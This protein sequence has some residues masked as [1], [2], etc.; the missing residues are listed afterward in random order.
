LQTLIASGGSVGARIAQFLSE[1]GEGVTLIDEDRQRC[2]WVSK[3]SDAHV[4]NGSLLDPALLMEAGIDKTD[5]LVVALENDEVTRKLVDLAKSQFGVPR[6]IA[7]AS[8]PDVREKLRESGADKVVVTEDVVLVQLES[9]LNASGRFTIFND[10]E[11]N[12]KIERT[13]VRATSSALG[14][15]VSSLSNRTAKIVAIG[16][17]GRTV[18]PGEDTALEMGDEVFIVGD[19][20]GV[21]QLNLAM[22]G[23]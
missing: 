7:V 22:E 18:F 20:R 19:E 4:Y 9:L 23:A 12:R 11:D 15:S 8:N 14:K 13:A 17:G 2:E 3:H 6:V 1:R 16:R 5:A 10:R 21:E